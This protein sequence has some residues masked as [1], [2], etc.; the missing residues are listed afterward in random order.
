MGRCGWYPE[1][2]GK[3][4]LR[5]LFDC[6]DNDDLPLPIRLL[7][8]STVRAPTA[9]NR[10]SKLPRWFLGSAA[11]VDPGL[12]RLRTASRVTLTLALVALGLLALHGLV[13]LAPAAF[14]IAMTLS[15]QG[16]LTIRDSTRRG[17]T[18]TRLCAA[19]TGFATT[20]V[21]SLL[22]RWPLAVDLLFLLVVFAAVFARKGGPR[23]NAVGMFAFMSYFIGAYLRPQPGDLGGIA[24]AI[25][26][27]V[28]IAHA[29]R[30]WIIPDRPAED[31]RN[32]L[33]AIDR[34]IGSVVSLVRTGRRDG[35]N[36]HSRQAVNKASQRVRDALIVAEGLLPTDTSTTGPE[37]VG[38][39]LSIKLFDIAL[40]LESVTAIGTTSEWD[41]QSETMLRA[42]LDR[43]ATARLD[44]RHAAS[45]MTDAMLEAARE[46]A[47]KQAPGKSPLS[48][49]RDPASRLAIQVTLAS[50][51]AMV[52]GIAV[53]RDRW[54]WAV[55]TAFLIFI[56]TQSRGDLAVRGLN[57]A[58]G[59]AAGIVLGIAL[60]TLVN[61]RVG[62]SL[63]LI[64]AFVFCGFYLLQISYGALTFFM[65]LALSLVYG[66]LGSFSPDLL[67]LRLAETL[68]GSCAGIFVAFFV[69]PRSTDA[70]IDKAIDGFL[71]ELDRLVVAYA[72]RRSGSGSTW[73]SVA[74][75]RVLD[76][77]L[78]DALTA[79][80]PLESTLLPGQ[81]RSTTRLARLRLTVLSYWAH[82]LAA[83][84]ADADTA[85]ADLDKAIERC[86]AEIAQARQESGSFF[87][88]NADTSLMPYQGL[89]ARNRPDAPN[90]A[91]ALH[92][93]RHVLAQTG[94][95]SDLPG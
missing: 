77:R 20:S 15:F 73:R 17:R 79:M 43:L 93:I 94:N 13:P 25:L 8:S 34:R 75:T 65:T 80:K 47:T 32:T 16:S 40:A 76:R 53:S 18:W 57:R 56:N 19:V 81:R 72:E 54:F 44:A 24:L 91:L 38:T 14:G 68:V 63:T 46:P 51:L 89:T 10:L 3:F 66:L 59:T 74:I 30:D 29:V 55:L 6:L 42:A 64:C 1:E 7:M 26:L 36:P 71:A 28:L 2:N 27:A 37:D 58:V 48:F 83:S 67:I 69:F 9:L 41:R 50:A 88:K 49:W 70:T 61:G 86:R 60:A 45:D 23:W 85:D 35:W 12:I 39:A 90:A 4:R 78:G 31:F 92:A 95:G 21:V 5:K 84:P 22:D 33:R 11:A 62:V 52:G 82:R 87:R